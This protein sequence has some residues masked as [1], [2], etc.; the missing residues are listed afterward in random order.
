M[1]R[2]TTTVEDMLKFPGA[3]ILILDRN[4]VE[5]MASMH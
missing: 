4:F 2:V 1:Q 3:W 5:L